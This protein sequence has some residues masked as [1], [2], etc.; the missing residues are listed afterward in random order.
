MTRAR[1]QHLAPASKVGT[2]NRLLFFGHTIKRP[3]DRLV[4][5]VLRSLLDSSW[6][7]PRGRKRK[8]WTEVKENLRTLGMDWQFRPDAR[9]RRLW[10]RD[11]WIGP[12][13]A[14]AEDCEG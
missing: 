14:L 7:R 2:E 13:Q 3:A 12:V 11:E 8:F 6:K 9:F 4:Q 10:N 5:R 1:Y